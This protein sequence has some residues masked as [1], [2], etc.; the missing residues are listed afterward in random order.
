MMVA[1]A[2]GAHAGGRVS[3]PSSQQHGN[4]QAARHHVAARHR[5]SRPTAVAQHLVPLLLELPGKLGFRTAFCTAVAVW[6]T[7][8]VLFLGSLEV[9][10][11]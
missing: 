2:Q 4:R 6:G 5:K 9:V 8:L 10:R 7:A 3:K 1:S 11:W